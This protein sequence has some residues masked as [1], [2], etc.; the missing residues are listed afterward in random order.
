MPRSERVEAASR[1]AVAWG[2]RWTLVEDIENATEFGADLGGQ[3]DA[4][5]FAAGEGGGGTVERE[6]IQAHGVEEFEA[7]ADFVHDAA[8]DDFVAAL[9]GMFLAVAR[10][11]RWATR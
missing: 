3:A 9:E 1:V 5:A 7:F 2:S 6:V 11:A 10:R 8:G 4:L